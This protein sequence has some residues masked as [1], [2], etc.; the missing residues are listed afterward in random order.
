MSCI[1]S[2]LLQLSYSATVIF[3]VKLYEKII[4]ISFRAKTFIEQKFHYLQNILFALRNFQTVVSDAITYI[5]LIH[6]PTNKDRVKGGRSPPELQTLL[7]SAIHPRLNE[8]QVD[9]TRPRGYVRHLPI[10]LYVSHFI[11]LQTNHYLIPHNSLWAFLP[12]LCTIRGIS[13]CI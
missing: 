10:F 9:F 4:I 13:V 12:S 5:H 2:L 7:A 11:T 8:G 3:F 1:L 6:S